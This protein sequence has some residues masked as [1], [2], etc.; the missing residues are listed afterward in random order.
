MEN[1]ATLLNYLLMDLKP[2]KNLCAPG[3]GAGL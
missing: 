2:Y 3:F 1:Y